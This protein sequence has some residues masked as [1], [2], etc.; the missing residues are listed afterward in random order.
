MTRVV[1]AVT[2][3]L[4]CSC[5]DS[6]AVSCEYDPGRECEDAGVDAVTD[7]GG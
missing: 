3:L 2:T 6:H 4:L 7:G 5:V 1:V